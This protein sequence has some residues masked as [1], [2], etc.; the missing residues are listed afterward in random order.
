M[1]ELLTL[2]LE[3]LKER[4]FRVNGHR[5]YNGSEWFFLSQFNH[6]TITICDVIHQTFDA[7]C[8]SMIDDI[9]EYLREMNKVTE[10]F[11]R[12]SNFCFDE[13]VERLD[14]KFRRGKKRG[15]TLS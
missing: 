6:T 14:K 9:E 2:V 4:G 13:A 15:A 12:S 1:S 8:P 5:V 10:E 7:H 11:R 3:C